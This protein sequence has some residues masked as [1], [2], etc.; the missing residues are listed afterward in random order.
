MTFA[1]LVNTTNKGRMPILTRIAQST[2]NL[3]CSKSFTSLRNRSS[4]SSWTKSIWRTKLAP[5]S[6]VVRR[7]RDRLKIKLKMT[8]VGKRL[9][10]V[11]RLKWLREQLIHRQEVSEWV[12]STPHEVC[13]T[14]RKTFHLS[15]KCS[16]KD[17]PLKN[18]TSNSW[19][20]KCRDRLRLL[21]QTAWPGL[22]EILNLWVS[23]MLRLRRKI[24]NP[25]MNLRS[26][27]SP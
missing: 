26:R 4:N 9:R 3:K 6:S 25:T 24:K 22:R 11:P 21:W 1:L 15:K 23:K 20:T 5:K 10:V 18:K 17:Y 8:S 14:L 19:M 2:P 13:L 16:S 27:H 7:F 12:L